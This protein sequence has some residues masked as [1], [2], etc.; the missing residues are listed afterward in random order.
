MRITTEQLEYW[1]DVFVQRGLSRYM[2][3]PQ[4]L[5]DPEGICRQF[6]QADG[7]QGF[8]PLLLRQREVIQAFR[9]A[10][11]SLCDAIDDLERRVAECLVRRGGHYF[12]P[13][14]HHA[15]PR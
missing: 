4:F 6:D 3:L 13:M 11:P 2:T 5:R 8:R 14:K 10:T 7:E 15:H 9:N 1:S 12:E